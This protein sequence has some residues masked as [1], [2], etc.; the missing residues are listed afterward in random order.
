MQRSILLLAL[1]GAMSPAFAADDAV[2]W[3]LPWRAGL[4]VTHAVTDYSV[5]ESPGERFA[6]RMTSKSTDRIV[7][8]SP[9]GFVLQSSSADEMLEVEGDAEREKQMRSVMAAFAG[10]EAR[11]ELDASGRVGDIHVDP[12][13]LARIL[14]TGGPIIREM[15]ESE[16]ESL[17]DETREIIAPHKDAIIEGIVQK[18]FGAESIVQTTRD[19][20]FVTQLMGLTYLPGVPHELQGTM[21]DTECGVVPATVS[22]WLDPTRTD[23]RLATV[24]FRREAQPADAQ[25]EDTQEGC[26]RA[27]FSLLEEGDITFDRETGIIETMNERE[28]RR[29]GESNR[30][31]ESE[32][33][34]IPARP[35]GA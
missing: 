11:V 23:A 3:K 22:A 33:H 20:F 35:E 19:A 6:Y 21:D 30:T 25:D 1:C 17:P 29:S 7:D 34:R 31:S 8:A 10:M 5:E 13:R 28:L 2:T 27:D 26:G 16:F 4:E 14:A 9:N 12:A 24:K 18:A 15:M 32:G